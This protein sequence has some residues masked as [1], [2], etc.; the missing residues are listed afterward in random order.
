MITLDK[1]KKRRPLR[2]ALEDSQPNAANLKVIGIGGGGGNA[3]N[4]MINAGLEGVH[5]LAA[6]SDCQALNSNRSPVKIQLGGKLTKGLG[7]G[8]NP[9]IGRSAALEDTETM[10]S[11]HLASAGRPSRHSQSASPGSRLQSM[12]GLRSA[13]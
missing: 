10:P 11:N 7:A 6:N 8:A 1:K 12:I 5:F 9:E 3:V 4:R 2:L 13:R